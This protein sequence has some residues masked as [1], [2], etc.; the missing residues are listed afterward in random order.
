MADGSPPADI[1]ILTALDML[2]TEVSVR[3]VMPEKWMERFVMNPQVLCL[4]D[5]APDDDPES[6]NSHVGGDDGVIGDPMPTV[7]SVRPEVTENWMDR[8]VV[9]L[10]EC[11]SVSR[12]S[13]VA[14]TFG[15]AVSEEYSPLFLPRRNVSAERDMN[16]SEVSAKREEI[17]DSLDVDYAS[18]ELND[19][20][21]RRL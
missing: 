11:A 9:D 14:R 4:D 15:P 18:V 7:V 21:F 6:R 2:Q 1:D 5:L 19:L 3:A 16:Y 20:T 17:D 10:V 13:A 12:T 8:F